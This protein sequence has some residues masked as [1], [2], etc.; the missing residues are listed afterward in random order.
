MESKA[1]PALFVLGPSGAGKS[2]LGNALSARLGWLHVEFDQDS[3]DGV[4]K[5]GLREEWDAFYNEHQADR[6]AAT[7]QCRATAGGK[8][9][10]VV[11]MPSLVVLMPKHITAATAAGISTIVLYGTG[12]EC[13]QAF[14]QR[15]VATGR[16]LTAE[17]WISNNAVTYAIHSRPEYAA[18]RVSAFCFGSRRP[19]EEVVAEVC[20]RVGARLGAQY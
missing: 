17:H 12:A 13:L 6:L 10:L 16:S 3:Q 11:S 9:G 20:C 1:L 19:V 4:T 8:S 18:I 5:S 2:S 14:L 7:L 15:E